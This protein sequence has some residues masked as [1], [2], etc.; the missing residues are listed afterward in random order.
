MGPFY[1]FRK[2]FLR[3]GTPRV[4]TR[5][6]QDASHRWNGYKGAGVSHGECYNHRIAKCANH[7]RHCHSLGLSTHQKPDP[8][9]HNTNLQAGPSGESYRICELI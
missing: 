8:N 3:A 9:P 7:H 6:P 4:G 2:A 1:F 5:E